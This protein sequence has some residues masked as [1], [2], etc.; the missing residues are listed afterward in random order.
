MV[1]R[2][3][4]LMEQNVKGSSIV[5]YLMVLTRLS[6]CNRAL[7]G[8]RLSSWRMRKGVTEGCIY[9]WLVI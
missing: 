5:L 9:F 1:G 6:T 7:T 3:S 2:Y 4:E 8:S